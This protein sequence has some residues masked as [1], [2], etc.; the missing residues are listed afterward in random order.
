MTPTLFTA[1]TAETAERRQ[2]AMMNR[3]QKTENGG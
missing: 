1:E 3:E 2:K